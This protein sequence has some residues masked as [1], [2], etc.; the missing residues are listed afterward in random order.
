MFSA[1]LVTAVLWAVFGR[2]SLAAAWRDISYWSGN[3]FASVF[4]P[5][6]V[7]VIGSTPLV[8]VMATSCVLVFSAA[9]AF[10]NF[11]RAAPAQRSS[12]FD[13]TF[14]LTLFLAIALFE[15]RPYLE[16][17]DLQNLQYIVPSLLLIALYALMPLM[18]PPAAAIV[19]SIPER[20]HGA[21]KWTAVV[22]FGLIAMQGLN[23]LADLYV[24]GAGAVSPAK[25]ADTSIVSAEQK[26]IV[27]EMSAEIKAQPCFFALSHSA[28]W[29][30]LFDQPSCSAFY[31]PAYARSAGA[32]QE[33]I[34]ELKRYRPRIV[35]AVDGKSPVLDG[36]TAQD[37]C[38]EVWAYLQA[39]YAPYRSL[40]GREFYRL[41]D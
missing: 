5:V 31:E 32:Q 22:L 40:D 35:L 23:P 15:F 16:R 11:L 3:A 17:A 39:A 4:M 18:S 20:R 19:E 13:E 6:H 28:V 9:R 21:L 29:Y 27:Q 37:T 30:Y 38:P 24:M 26:K 2:T 41:R 8:L 14:A 1:V 12:D 25:L 7:D 34:T 33:V 10:R 36:F